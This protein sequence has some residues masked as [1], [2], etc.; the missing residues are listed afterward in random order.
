MAKIAASHDSAM[1]DLAVLWTAG[2]SSRSKNRGC[3]AIRARADPQPPVSHG[4]VQHARFFNMSA[5]NV[6][7]GIAGD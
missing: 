2:Q 7:V 3:P 1:T 5:G 6:F 4:L